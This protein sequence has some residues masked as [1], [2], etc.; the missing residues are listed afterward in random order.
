[1][2]GGGKGGGSAPTPPDPVKTA[3]AQSAANAETARVQG[4]MNRVNQYTP[5][6]N[7]TWQPNP[8]NQAWVDQQL[9]AAKDFRT[10]AGT[11][12][13]WDEAGDR[14]YF[15]EQSP[16]RDSYNM[17]TELSPAQKILQ[18]YQEYGQGKYGEAAANQLDKLS[19][20]L[21]T[22][23]QGQ[24]YASRT[25]ALGQ[26]AQDRIGALNNLPGFQDTTGGYRTA[27]GDMSLDAAQKAAGLAGQPIN[28]DYNAVRQQAID[29]ANSRLNPQFAQ[30]E[31]S[32]RA[33]LL[34]SGHAEGSKGWENAYRTFNQGRNDAR[35]QTILN[36]E[37]L[38]G[39]SIQQTGALRGIPMGELSQVQGMAGNLGNVAGTIQGQNMANYQMPFQTGQNIIG[40]AG[41][42]ANLANQGFNQA[43]A[44]RNQPLNETA[45]LL[46]GNMV[47]TPQSQAIPTTQVAPTDLIN[48][49]MGSYGG[50]LQAYNAQQQAA[51]ANMGGLY[52]LASTGVMAAGMY[53]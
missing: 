15:M 45:A 9:A 33:R 21:S 8:Q 48:A 19:G 40:L 50:Q 13:T 52:G 25:D 7:I 14:K 5:Y 12:D 31:E 1:M 39:Q 36:A 46:T 32:M 16:Y 34:A 26:M 51:A 28:T 38:A 23:F 37:N 30:D 47:Q 35:M 17:T 53:F 29:A 10:K 4:A 6:G 44:T 43:I 24:P 18:T 2:A 20:A 42:G 49:T 11:L 41:Q 27:A 22:P 3:Q